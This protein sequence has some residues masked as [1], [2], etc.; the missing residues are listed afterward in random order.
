MNVEKLNQWLVFAANMGVL[1]GILFL[2]Y[3]IRQNTSQ[4]RTE[5]SHSITEMVNSLNADEYS[6][7]NLTDLLLR[8][9]Q[10][11]NGLSPIEQYR[12]GQF[13]FAKI[14]LAQYILLLEEEGL[15]DVQFPYVEVTVDTIRRN[16]G[17]RDW[18][19]SV[20]DTWVGSEELWGKL[21][22]PQER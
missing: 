11:F 2:A 10:N 19:K 17:A 20:E 18:L 14:N 12:Y 9:N 16:P 21:N 13:Q 4:M 8:G 1:G 15:T 6:D 5:A 22:T 7:P 3:E